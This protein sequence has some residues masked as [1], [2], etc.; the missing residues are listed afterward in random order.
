MKDYVVWKSHRG[1]D[2]IVKGFWNSIFY[3]IKYGYVR[4]FIWF[5]LDEVKSSEKLFR[6]I[7]K[8]NKLFCDISLLR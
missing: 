5:I 6:F 2:V 7:A 8:R 4:D 1:V 3:R